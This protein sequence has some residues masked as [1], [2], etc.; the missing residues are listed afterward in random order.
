MVAALAAAALLVVA[1]GLIAPSAGAATA[2]PSIDMQGGSYFTAGTTISA[3]DS[4]PAIAK[5][6]LAGTV[7]EEKA[8]VTDL[9][10]NIVSS[11]DYTSGS[12]F[13]TSIRW[14]QE[15][16]YPGYSN[17]D[18]PDRV[19]VA[20][21]GCEEAP[22]ASGWDDQVAMFPELGRYKVPTFTGSWTVGHCS[23]WQSNDGNHDAYESKGPGSVATLTYKTQGFA[24][25]TDHAMGRGSYDIYVDGKK[26]KS[27]SDAASKTTNNIVDF[28]THFKTYA[29]H[30]FKIVVTKGRIDYITYV[31]AFDLY[32]PRHF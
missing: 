9:D 15:A 26:V 1:G 14:S 25:V 3:A 20:V 31:A 5:W 22:P 32:G 6:T 29:N 21:R 12:R 17:G 7:C 16:Y 19:Y 28:Q 13:P 10:G 11:F 27:I 4:I 2:A 8:R 23:C 24:L 18:P 30:T